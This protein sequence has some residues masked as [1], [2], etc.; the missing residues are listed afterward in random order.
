MRMLNINI[1]DKV[2]VI[3]P[4]PVKLDSAI[5]AGLDEAREVLR[6]H[7]LADFKVV[8][9][10]ES[11]VSSSNND[12]TRSGAHIVYYFLAPPTKISL[13][14][15]YVELIDQIL[16]LC[17]RETI[18]EEAISQLVFRVPEKIKRWTKNGHY[19]NVLRHAIK[20]VLVSLLKQSAILLP[21]NMDRY[22]PCNKGVW[23]GFELMP[24][25][26]KDLSA[27][28]YAG[29][30]LDYGVDW[31]NCTYTANGTRMNERG[32]EQIPSKS[33]KITL[34]H[35][36][37]CTRWERLE[38]IESHDIGV[39]KQLGNLYTIGLYLTYLYL[40][41]HTK[42][43]IVEKTFPWVAEY[44][45]LRIYVDAFNSYSER[46]KRR[47]YEAK[48]QLVENAD[49][50]KLPKFDWQEFKDRL[51]D[52]I[53]QTIQ[54][55]NVDAIL[56]A[57]S[58]GQMKGR[59]KFKV[60]EMWPQFSM[61]PNFI[62]FDWVN[63][64]SFWVSAFNQYIR[65]TSYLYV[66]QELANFAPFMFY[67]SV[68][69]PIY[70]H[71][72]PTSKAS[73]PKRL[74]DLNGYYFISRPFDDKSQNLP[75]PYVNFVREYHRERSSGKAYT[76]IRKLHHF[77]ELV[78]SRR[79]FLGVPSQITNPVLETDIPGTGGRPTKTTKTRLPRKAF[80]L[81]LLYAYKIY[82]YVSAINQKSL[83]DSIFSNEYPGMF[84]QLDRDEF[85]MVDIRDILGD[86]IDSIVKFEGVE[87]E[88]NLVPSYF[89]FPVELPVKSKGK[90]FLVRP[91]S[92]THLLCALETG[93]RNQHIQWLSYDY[94][95][96]IHVSNIN[97]DDVY[98][99]YVIT[100]KT[101][102]SWAALTSGR[103]IK[104][105]KEMQTFRD[106]IDAEKFNS[107]I[108]YEGIDNNTRYQPYKVLFA[109]N[110]D[111]G[112]PHSDNVYEAGFSYLMF[113]LQN[114][115]DYFDVG[116]NLF[117]INDNHE[118]RLIDKLSPHSLRVTVVSEYTQFLDS[119]YVGRY[120]T[121]QKLATVW[122]YSKYDADALRK[123][124]ADQQ[125]GLRQLNRD[126]FEVHLIGGGGITIDT[127][128][129]NSIL[130]KAFKENVEQAIVDFGA[131]SSHFFDRDTGIA[132][133]TSN[134]KL[135]LA[136]EPTHIC[137][138]NRICPGDRHKIG[139]ANRCN[140]CD[141]AIRTVDHLPSLGCR[142]RDLLEELERLEAF[143][144]KNK[145]ELTEGQERDIDA[146]L[147]VIA[148]DLASLDLAEKILGE[149]LR[150]LQTGVEGETIH[151][152]KPESVLKQ[153]QAIPFP[154]IEDESRYF[155]ARL[156]EVKSFPDDTRH[157]LKMKL[158]TLRNRIL[159]NTD[160]IRELLRRGNDIN[161]IEAQVYS[162]VN[163]IRTAHGLSL[164]QVAEIASRDIETMIQL[165]HQPTFLLPSNSIPI[166]DAYMS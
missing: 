133:V 80:W 115:L 162:L 101:N 105:L 120:I 38:D 156:E 3:E 1:T 111:T 79:E 106:I 57:R 94:D 113:G 148:E 99:L 19:K 11:R 50:E 95:K 21:A 69:L 154:D 31:S 127:T 158:L 140:F 160:N 12:S 83:D 136:F 107:K 103:V 54:D 6:M 87:Y 91:N 81:G 20:A 82:D 150:Q 39:L 73:Y 68:Y 27:L 30:G 9:E 117:T 142:R 34:V 112:H 151:V 37:M 24:E 46:A 74:E 13:L 124:Q 78:L 63:Q 62:S 128:N 134:T 135:T 132:I 92:I 5:R 121:N 118:I 26:L 23:R 4:N 14:K 97:I 147:S 52:V 100:D 122:Y 108:N 66:D 141:Y 15:E 55:K 67:L 104:T 89:L 41:A 43:T 98:Q 64:L 153:L 72:N 42:D 65:M 36:A 114:L 109:F 16:N 139:Y 131:V 18:T 129:P 125:T 123:L 53:I 102:P 110:I 7:Y 138:F 130:T 144:D 145:A 33:T 163:S 85:G 84:R 70:F 166:E 61:L 143:A 56:L 152:Y 51:H 71:L 88:V 77:F 35:F 22:L 10:F 17:C 44:P 119:E 96:Y 76:S 49:S 45:F 86:S 60:N 137:P 157:L 146:R 59:T 58:L 164:D 149:N 32:V 93:I 25:R 47:R 165:D 40:K 155:L 75:L 48:I 161:R 29:S 8:P 116:F 159:A 126:K 90:R 28:Y 2:V